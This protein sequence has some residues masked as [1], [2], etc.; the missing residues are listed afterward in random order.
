MT[1]TPTFDL[2]QFKPQ[3]FQWH[4]EGRVGIITLNR[5]E[6]KN[7][8]TFESYAELRDFFRAL[9]GVKEVRA[10]VITGAGGNFCSGGD[11]HEIIGPL[12]RMD[13]AGLRNFTQMTGDL[14]KAMRACPQPIIAAVDG[15]CAGAGAILAMASDFRLGTPRAKTAFLFTRVGLAGC[16]MGACAI[17]PRIIGQGRASELLF[18]GRSMLAEEGLAWGFFNRLIA[19]ETV[20]AESLVLATEIAQGPTFAHALTKKML[21]AEWSMTVDE[22]IDAEAEAQAVCMETQ[23]FHR[24]YHAFVAKQKPKF[25]G[26]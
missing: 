6:R 17:L 16:D 23:D 3:H 13:A 11:V 9:V 26:D 21:H 22:A 8:L 25:E 10:L 18:T 15:V 12:T 5:P 14:V 1:S 2:A 7:P 4:Q 24:A 20:L 19:P